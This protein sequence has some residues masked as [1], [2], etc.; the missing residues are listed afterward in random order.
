MDIGEGDPEGYVN[1]Y[2]FIY[3]SSEE[4]LNGYLEVNAPITAET[5]GLSKAL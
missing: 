2:R 5:L 1:I 4:Y 3:T